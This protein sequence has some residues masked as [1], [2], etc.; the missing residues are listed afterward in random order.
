SVSRQACGAAAWITVAHALAGL[1]ALDGRKAVVLLSEDLPA[2][3]EVSGLAI[4]KTAAR[5]AAAIYQTAICR[6]SGGARAF[7]ESN[8]G[9][10]GVDLER[11][12]R[13]TA[14]YYVL[15]VNAA[16]SARLT[17]SLRRPELTLRSRAE[18]MSLPARYAF[19]APRPSADSMREAM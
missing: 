7:S 17:V 11:V 3:D 19:L 14:A 5:A 4:A 16:G 10:C 9:A 18:P 1:Q 13:E 2:P 8:G 12:L 15:G 6:T